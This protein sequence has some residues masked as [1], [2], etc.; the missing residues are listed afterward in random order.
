MACREMFVLVCKHE[1]ERKIATNSRDFCW[2]DL[3][4]KLHLCICQFYKKNPI[5]SHF[6]KNISLPM[7]CRQMFVVVHTRIWEKNC[8]K[9]RQMQMESVK[10]WIGKR[11]QNRQKIWTYAVKV[12]SLKYIKNIAFS[13]DIFNY[14]CSLTAT[15]VME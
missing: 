2:S 10:L 1:I 13:M 8:P 5:H 15:V 3:L 6:T 9:I 4:P 14:L 7:A 12:C 11:T